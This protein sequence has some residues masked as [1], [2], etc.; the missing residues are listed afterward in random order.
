[1]P[2]RMTIAPRGKLFGDVACRRWGAA[3]F[4]DGLGGSRGS[5]APRLPFEAASN[6]PLAAVNNDASS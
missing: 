1:M 3:T 2:V 6:A 4:T 5:H